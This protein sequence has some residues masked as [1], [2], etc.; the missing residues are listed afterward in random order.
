VTVKDLG[1]EQFG[2]IGRLVEF[3][4]H[5]LRSGGAMTLAKTS[6]KLRT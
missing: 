6:R 2:E 4:G 1:E 5:C 3:L